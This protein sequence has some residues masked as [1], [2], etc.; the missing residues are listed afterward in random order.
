MNIELL[1]GPRSRRLHAAADRETLECLRRARQVRF[2]LTPVDVRELPGTQ[3]RVVA[4]APGPMRIPGKRWR[5][6]LAEADGTVTLGPVIAIFTSSYRRDPRRR[7]ASLSGRFRRFVQHARELGALAYVFTPRGVHWRQKMITGF[8]WVGSGKRGRWVRGSFP[9]PNVVYN[10]VPTRKAEQ[11]PRVSAVRQRLLEYPELHLFN[12]KFLDK[13]QV[14]Q[15]LRRVEGVREHLPET[16]LYT[17]V[18]DLLPFLQRHEHVYLKMASGSLGRG[19]ARIDLLNDGKMRWRATRPGRQIA[20]R[21]LSGRKELEAQVRRLSRRGKYLMQQGISLLKANG[22]PFDVRALVQKEP[23]GR[24][25]VTGMAARIAGPRQITTHRPRGGSRAQLSP[26]IQTVFRNPQ[27]ASRVEE[28]L[29]R[30]I[31][32]AAEA[33]DRETGGGHGEL[34]MDVAIDGNGHPWVLELNAK[35]A[36]FD[37]PAIRRQAERRLLNYCFARS[38]FRVPGADAAD[39]SAAGPGLGTPPAA[40]DFSA[41]PL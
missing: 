6:H 1:T 25:T 26:L 41:Y 39:P 28:E 3:R 29:R 21:L 30:V 27:S 9:F 31:V 34:S 2:G 17:R 11:R 24:W 14:Y 19:T 37:E 33:F 15:I 23:N 18:A 13:W 40:P 4:T 35:P 36:V 16:R 5:L 10:R 22:R 20:A 7:F 38:G 12:P 32:Q 8:T